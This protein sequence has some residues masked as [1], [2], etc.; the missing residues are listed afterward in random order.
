MKIEI[1]S[2]EELSTSVKILHL[3]SGLLLKFSEPD[4]K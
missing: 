2:G 3:K 4:E 1:D